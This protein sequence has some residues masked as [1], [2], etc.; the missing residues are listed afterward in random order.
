MMKFGTAGIR[1][2]IGDGSDKMNIPQVNLA[3]FALSQFVI[4]QNLQKAG[5]VISYDTRRMSREFA[6]AAAQ[7]FSA[8]KIKT[9]IFENVRPVPMVSFAVRHLGAAAGVMITASHNP[10][11]YNGYKVFAADG[12]QMALEETELVA[13]EMELARG[14]VIPT[15]RLEK[16]DIKG[17]ENLWLNDYVQVIGSTV[18]E[19][20]FAE[21]KKLALSSDAVAKVKND[22]KI[23]YTPIH[24][25]GKM[26]VSSMLTQLGIPFEMVAEQAEADTEFSTVSVP[27]PEDKETLELGAALAKKIGADFVMGTDPDC[28]RMGAAIKNDKGEFVMLSGNQ[29]GAIIMDYILLRLKQ[30]GKLPANGAVC[31]TIVT[32]NLADNIAKE[33]GVKLFAV[34]TGFK[35]IGEKIAE[36]EKS[37]EHTFVFGYEESFGY[38]AGTHARDKDA[39]VACMLFAEAACFYKT[40]GLTMWDRLQKLY[41]K[42]GYFV[43]K[44]LNFGF[45]GETAVAE[46]RNAMARL[47]SLENKDRTVLD[48]LRPDTGLP[49]SDV[50]KF[51]YPCGSWV[52]VRG[53]G[54]EP[55]LK[56]Y[57]SAVCKTAE[58][59]EQKATDLANKFKG[60]LFPI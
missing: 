7:V 2:L 23:I 14:K 19:K 49:V 31:K 48:Y 20:Y 18:D 27:N 15:A 6:L 58:S 32:T 24:G 33:Y 43:E 13:R 11:E 53:S 30:T 29:T 37:G 52:A 5:I 10:K 45:T 4:K 54:T 25:S 17:Q 12:A 16:S 1:G 28:D 57:A 3:S 41:K 56:L 55:K 47:R 36:W 60:L 59:A 46:C 35:F 22:L 21:I 34:L 9:Y 42:H 51:V 8:A 44:N 38:L 40:H 26:P 50:L 39:V